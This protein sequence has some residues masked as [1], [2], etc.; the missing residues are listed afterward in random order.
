MDIQIVS[1][2]SI[3]TIAL[4]LIQ[5]PIL[6]PIGLASLRLPKVQLYVAQ[7]KIMKHIEGYC[8]GVGGAW[9]ESAMPLK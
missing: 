6:H 4:D 5:V 9:K 2:D 7:S 3:T 8:A 1:V